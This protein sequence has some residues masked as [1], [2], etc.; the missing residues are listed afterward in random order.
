M[1]EHTR[2]ATSLTGEDAGH[3][4]N[5]RTPAAASPASPLP[6]VEILAD[7]DRVSVALRG[8]L[9]L[10][11]A[12]RMEPEL[13]E[14]LGRSPRGLDLHLD[15]VGFCDCAGLNLLLRLRLRALDQDKTVAIRSSSRAVERLLDLAG[16]RA[17]F[18]PPKPTGHDVTGSAALH[19]KGSQQDTCQALSAEVAQLRRAMQTRPTIDLARGILMATFS[20]SPDAAWETLVTASQ[21]TNTKLYRLAQGL[22]NCVQGTALPQTVQQQLAAAVAKAKAAPTSLS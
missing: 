19:G 12:R 8:E 5:G 22:V 6:A 3:H 2:R 9:D 11:V 20:L 16:A 4:R 14:I 1:P 18:V 21:N 17:L 10:D 15:A 13:H 7:G